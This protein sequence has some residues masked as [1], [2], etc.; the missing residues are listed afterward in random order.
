MACD[1]KANK[2][3]YELGVRYGSTV[4]R[5]RKDVLKGGVWTAVQYLFLAIF[6]VLASPVIFSVIA[7]KAL[8]RKERVFRIDEM[9]GLKKNR[10]VRE[11][12]II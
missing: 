11:Q 6:A 2:Q 9:V 7:W 3:I 4:G 1:C 10:D 8:V 5:T 12:Q